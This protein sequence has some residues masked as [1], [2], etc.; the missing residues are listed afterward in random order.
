MSLIKLILYLFFRLEN[1]LWIPN[2]KV[3]LFLGDVG[4]AHKM[5]Y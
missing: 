1:P 2:E 5:A 4:L 3:G